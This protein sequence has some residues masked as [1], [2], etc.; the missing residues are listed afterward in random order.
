[1]NPRTWHSGVRVHPWVHLRR[2]ATARSA[3]DPSRLSSV[4]RYGTVADQAEVSPDSKRLES[5]T[6]ETDGRRLPPF[7]LD[8]SRRYCGSTVV[9]S[10][11]RLS[12]TEP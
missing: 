1:M 9:G 5:E 11:V 4:K 2:S 3:V 10:E 6:D 7:E 8:R 12:S